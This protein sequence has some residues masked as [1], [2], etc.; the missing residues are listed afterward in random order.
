MM[1]SPLPVPECTICRL[2]RALQ[3]V[4]AAI[5]SITCWAILALLLPLVAAPLALRWRTKACNVTRLA[6]PCSRVLQATPVSRSSNLT[7]HQ[8]QR[9]RIPIAS[10]RLYNT[11]NASLPILPS[12]QPSNG[13]TDLTTL[14]ASSAHSPKK[15]LPAALLLTPPRSH[16]SASSS[17]SSPRTSVPCSPPSQF[18]DEHCFT[19]EENED[20][21][22]ENDDDDDDDDEHE[23]DDEPF[24]DALPFQPVHEQDE[25]DD[26]FTYPDSDD[27][28][29]EHPVQRVTSPTPAV[30]TTPPGSPPPGC[31]LPKLPPLSQ[32]DV[33]MSRIKGELAAPKLSSVPAATIP[34]TSEAVPV[35]PVRLPAKGSQR[36]APAALALLSNHL[37]PSR[38]APPASKAHTTPLA[39][40]STPRPPPSRVVDSFD[41]PP[42]APSCTMA[43]YNPPSSPRLIPQDNVPLPDH[44]LNGV[45]EPAVTL[46]SVP[47]VPHAV[48]GSSLQPS[49]VIGACYPFT[50]T[51]PTAPTSVQTFTP[52]PPAVSA[53]PSCQATTP[54]P[55]FPS[56][57]L[58]DLETK[59]GNSMTENGEVTPKREAF[60]L[61]GTPSEAS[62]PFPSSLPLTILPA[63]HGSSF[64]PPHSTASRTPSP[65]LSPRT[66]A[67]STQPGVPLSLAL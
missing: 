45:E 36:I 63:S 27:A 33:V 32:L 38:A 21:D 64:G 34:P 61:L 31:K 25:D 67:V 9:S 24:A 11:S 42:A 55:V 22:D 50:W 39:L 19:N 54:W 59:D 60:Q 48:F 4:L 14:E 26:E 20:D 49:P 15:C 30:S 28:V 41:D 12:T 6:S 29:I 1:P 62:V 47:P 16:T 13:W 66:N 43:S 10:S 3:N 7:P 17:I 44:Y 51:A 8:S 40:H 57:A 23:D 35:P 56:K 5:T 37:N 58:V 2:V 53:L 52:S 46:A 18:P 65:P